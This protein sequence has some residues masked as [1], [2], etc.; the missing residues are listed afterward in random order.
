VCQEQ[1]DVALE[2]LLTSTESDLSDSALENDALTAKIRKLE[3]DARKVEFIVSFSHS[4]FM[5]SRF[6]G[7]I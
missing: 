4:D 7:F 5:S 2:L 6:E 1:V 3:E